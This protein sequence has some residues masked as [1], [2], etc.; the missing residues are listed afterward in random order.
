MKGNKVLVLK[1]VCFRTSSSLIFFSSATVCTD[2]RKL[3][4]VF[5]QSSLPGARAGESVSVIN[6]VYVRVYV[7][8]RVYETCTMSVYMSA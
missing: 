5:L 4:G 2:T 1:Y 7:Y 6:T 3:V 8:M